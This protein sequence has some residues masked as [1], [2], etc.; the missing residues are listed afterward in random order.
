MAVE[1]HP[2]HESVR[3]VNLRAGCHSKPPASGGYYAM[4]R[5]YRPDG[6][7]TNEQVWIPNNM[8]RT[9]RQTGEYRNGQWEEL[10]EC[11]GCTA[12][13]DWEFINKMRQLDKPV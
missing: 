1:D 2:V 6:S 11:K 4:H 5:E 7:F 13:R 12:E 9:C 8:S 3:H 10:D